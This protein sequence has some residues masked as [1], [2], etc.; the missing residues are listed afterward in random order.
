MCASGIKRECCFIASTGAH[1]RCDTE[2]EWEKELVARKQFMDHVLC[3]QA[4]LKLQNI[5]FCRC[6]NLCSG[7]GIIFIFN[8]DEKK[9]LCF[10][11]FFGSEKNII[12]WRRKE[13]RKQKEWIVMWNESRSYVH[14]HMLTDTRNSIFRI[15]KWKKRERKRGNKYKRNGFLFCVFVVAAGVV[16]VAVV[17]C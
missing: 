11:F 5:S 16:V 8:L 7:V 3:T 13:K 17:V 12:R 4:Y 6:Y 14:T 1:T 15:W 2:S 10:F 9:K